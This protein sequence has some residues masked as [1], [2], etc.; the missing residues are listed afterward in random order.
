MTLPQ[1]THVHHYDEHPVLLNV[2]D[3]HKSFPVAR[4]PID[5]LRRRPQRA[6]RALNGVS[7]AVR[8]GETLGIVGESGCGKSTLARC[9]V[10]LYDAN[11]GSITFNGTDVSN[12]SGSRLRAYNRRVQMVFQDPFN[13]LNPRMSVGQTLRE[14]VIVHKLRPAAQADARVAEL[15]DLVG[16]PQDAAGRLPHEF[17][18]GQRQRVAIARCLALE[19]DVLVADELV[20]ALDVSVQAQIINLLLEL[21]E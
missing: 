18:G 12:L 11:A 2:D 17:S 4:S 8:T 5:W 16:L 15:L 14:A 13:S 19:P 20:S 1:S 6:V 21:Q 9:I 7:L 10:R 3:L